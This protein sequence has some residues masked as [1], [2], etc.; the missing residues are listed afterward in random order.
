MKDLQTEHNKETT[1]QSHLE[2][3]FQ[4]KES[5]VEIIPGN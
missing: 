3:I 2:L 4:G 1:M 5:E